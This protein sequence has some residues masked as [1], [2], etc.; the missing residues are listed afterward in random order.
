MERR[1]FEIDG[2]NDLLCILLGKGL[3]SVRAGNVNADTGSVAHGDL[4]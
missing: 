2:R 1:S 4:F 3:R